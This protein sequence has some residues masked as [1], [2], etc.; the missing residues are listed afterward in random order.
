MRT[1]FP[2]YLI[3]DE[4][5]LVFWWVVLF[6]QSCDL[7]GVYLVDVCCVVNKP[8]NR[9]VVPKFPPYA[10]YI[11]P[12]TTKPHRFCIFD[13]RNAPSNVAVCILA[14]AVPEDPKLRWA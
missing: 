11:V 8:L 6:E 12:K 10:C 2:S 5:V 9:I 3:P 4:L 1:D 14:W 13:Y 7:C